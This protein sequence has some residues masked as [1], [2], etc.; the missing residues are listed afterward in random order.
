M[1]DHKEHFAV[2]GLEPGQSMAQVQRAYR[3]LIA[4][5]H[6]DRF[7]A[8][9][10]EQRYAEEQTK[11]L[12]QAYDALSRSPWATGKGRE[13]QAHSTWV[14][15]QTHPGWDPDPDVDRGAE[16]RV[17]RGRRAFA[18]L[19][20][21]LV[22]A[23]AAYAVFELRPQRSPDHELSNEES[24]FARHSGAGNA[25]VQDE[26]L[27]PVEADRLPPTAWM[28]QQ[29]ANDSA[30]RLI[31]VGSTTSE[32]LAALG[33]PMHADPSIWDYGPSRIYFKNG[34]VTGWHNS[35]FRPL[36]LETASPTGLQGPQRTGFVKG[37]RLR[38]PLPGG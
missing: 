29:S 21:L 36:P 31:R 8:G 12:N 24:T 11:V 22:L 5:W 6:P 17:S 38:S 28:P 34:L 16:R 18:R 30:P 14:P 15:P 4:R 25:Y 35:T 37:E 19:T 1:Q 23:I 20:G 27:R 26:T 10:A 33:P 13:S 9:S 32:V 3:Q 2:L 7:E